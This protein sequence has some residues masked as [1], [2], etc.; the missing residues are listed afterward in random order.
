M[1]INDFRESERENPLSFCHSWCL[2]MT[3]AT[4]MG[5]IVTAQSEQSSVTTNGVSLIFSDI[6]QFSGTGGTVKYNF[7]AYYETGS[8]YLIYTMTNYL[9]ADSGNG[10][11][12]RGDLGLGG[13][14]SGETSLYSIVGYTQTGYY[15]PIT[16][17]FNEYQPNN[18]KSSGS[19][20]TLTTGISATAGDTV[21]DT[22]LST[23]YSVEYSYNIPMF[24]LNPVSMTNGNA[25]WQFSDNQAQ[26]GTNPTSASYYVGTSVQP[27]EFEN[28]VNIWSQGIFGYHYGWFNALTG[29][30]YVSQHNYYEVFT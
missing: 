10:Y 1:I 19:A 16:E 8:G 29:S 17:V 3:T 7:S 26:T 4:A 27:A 28:Y 14:G 18:D 15:T 30:A 20:G 25:T 22:S 13:P 11:W 9:T 23:T 2:S 21:F 6:H 12:L 5:Q 24:E